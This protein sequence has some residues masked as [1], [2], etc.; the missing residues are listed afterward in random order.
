MMII[1]VHAHDNLDGTYR[2]SWCRRAGLSEKPSAGG[3]VHVTLAEH[4]REDRRILAELAALYHLLC[5]AEV[6]G[7]GR[8]GNGLVI[9]V[10]SGAIKKAV[11]KGTI[12]K[13]GTGRTD[14]P[15]VAHFAHFLATKFFEAEVKVG[16][17]PKEEPRMVMNFKVECNAPTVA[18]VQSPIGDVIVSR[19]ALNRFVERFTA[20]EY[21][22]AGMPLEKVPNEKWT[23]AWRRLAKNIGRARL[24]T[25][26]PHKEWQYIT[27]KYGAETR[28]LLNIDSDILFILK[29]EPHGL[30]LA[31]V[32]Q[33]K[34][35][36]D[37]IAP[38]TDD[39][40]FARRFLRMA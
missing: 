1:S 24:F 27:R 34:P 25:A 39:E 6:H 11:A 9:E 12:K 29:E 33:R 7:R 36:G 26:I 40:R 19:H 15:H 28:V 4:F 10:S 16:A 35:D 5:V 22:N 13:T 8:L 20:V 32:R 2:V 14:K 38:L 30:V 3:S 37:R 17:L 21:T 23:K 31:T 18:K